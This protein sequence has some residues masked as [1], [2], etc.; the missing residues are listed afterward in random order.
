MSQLRP[1]VARCVALKRPVDNPWRIAVVGWLVALQWHHRILADGRDCL[2][3][4]GGCGVQSHTQAH[5]EAH[6]SGVEVALGAA[7]Q[8]CTCGAERGD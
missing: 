4:A 5:I 8:V 7:S 6:S 1:H 2:I 3:V